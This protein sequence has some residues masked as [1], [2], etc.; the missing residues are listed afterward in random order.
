M[1]P[2]ARPAA[3]AGPPGPRRDPAGAPRRDRRADRAAGRRDTCRAT[4]APRASAPA[5]SSRSCA[6]TSPA[7]TCATSTP[8]GDR[9][10][11]PAARAPARARAHDD[12]VDRARPLAVDGVRH[13]GAA[14]VRRRR[15]HRARARAA[16]GPPRRQRR[17]RR[18]R[19]P[20]SRSCCRRAAARPGLAAVRDLLDAGVAPDGAARRAAGSPARS[21]RLAPLARRP[22]LVA[23]VSD[24][25]DQDDWSGPLAALR[26]ATRS[27]RSRSTTRARRAAGGRAARAGRSRERRAPRRSTP[28]R[29]RARRASRRS[30]ASAARQLAS[31]LR[32]A[33][34]RRTS[35]STPTSDWLLALARGPRAR[36]G[37]GSAG[38]LRPR[39]CGCSRCSRCPRRC[40][41][42]A[43]RAGARSRYALRFPPFEELAAA[44]AAER[45]L[46]AQDPRR[47]AAARARRARGRAR[48]PARRRRGDACAQASLVLVLDHSGS[49]AVDR[50]RRR[51]ASPRPRRAANAFLDQ[52]PSGIR[53]GVVG[54]S[55]APDIVL[56]P[57]RQPR[58]GASRDR[59]A[60]R[61]RRHRDRRRADG[62]GAPARAH[63]GHRSGRAAIVLLS[64]GAANAGQNPVRS[65]RRRRARAISIDTVALGTPGGTL[66]NPE[67]LRAADPGAPRP[68]ADAPDRARP[69]T[70]ATSPRRTP[71]ASRRSTA[72]WARALST[73]AVARA[74]SRPRSP[75]SGS[76]CCSAAAL[77]SLRWNGGLP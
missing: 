77:A 5:P 75:A 52:L 20:A 44:A 27:S 26:G 47:G 28:P 71:A 8:L 34:R 43:S 54:F 35:R 46:A 32:A 51:R 15:G 72:A 56:A 33:A 76:R 68:A 30:S 42:S 7:T 67:P 59:L 4:A 25:R 9:A 36:H 74:T 3:A 63:G 53:V 66:A 55:S 16:R 62:R 70:A 37:C 6:P 48:A 40:S 69:A 10:H 50:R 57:D 14:E 61:V 49:M 73:P 19:T 29:A 11:R 58:G 23:I 22:S 18:V 21:T 24:F 65:R 1:S 64:D 45:P 60:V 13:G 17:R 31:E 41:P 12:D 38:E 39:R 2:V